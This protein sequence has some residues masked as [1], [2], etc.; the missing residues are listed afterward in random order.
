VKTLEFLRGTGAD[1]YIKGERRRA[2]K[3]KR[4]GIEWLGND[5]KRGELI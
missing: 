4:E 5:K 2:S 3:L 1:T